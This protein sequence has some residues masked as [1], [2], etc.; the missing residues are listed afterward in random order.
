M[1][2]PLPWQTADILAATGGI[3]ISGETRR[4]FA[5]VSID[6]RSITP[7]EV[8]VAIKG[9]THDGHRFIPEAI[10][11]GAGG[12]LIEKGAGG[13]LP[14]ALIKQQRLIC[15]GVDD[16]TRALG[17]LAAFNRR[18]SRVSVVAVT[19]SNGKTTTR[20]MTAACVAG[21]FQVL[22]PAGNFNNQ[23]G[24]PLTL[25][26]LEKA[27]EWA[28]L[29]LGMNR[30][31]EIGRLAEICMPQIGVITN[32]GSAHIEG[33]GSIEGIMEAKGELLEKIDTG[34]SAV[35]NADDPRVLRLAGRAARNVLLFGSSKDAAVRCESVRREGLGTAFTLVLPSERISVC[36]KIPGSFM[37]SNALAAASVGHLIGLSGREIAS[38]LDAFEPASGRMSVFQTENGINIIDDTYNANPDSMA[39]A[40]RTLSSSL[41][42]AR[43]ILVMGDM[44]ELGR[45]AESMHRSIGALSAGSGIKRL[46]ATGEFAEAVAAGA[47]DAN[48]DFRQIVTGTKEEILNDLSGRLRPG[49]WVLVKGSRAMGMETIVA[50]LRTGAGAGKSGA[51]PASTSKNKG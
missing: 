2:H 37:V 6:S 19:G 45:H 8:F 34:G 48:M 25:L 43:G 38:G 17:D 49:D 35:L 5:G 13:G 16:T 24:L 28:V 15:V 26:K 23:I 32:I 1:T 18:R 29:E 33:L 39:A 7:G 12:L 31:G 46:Y 14:Q 9:D 47:V 10:R 40:I 22:E 50:R 51:D 30:P 20:K 4:S 44:L 3:L 42:G 27:H 21:R 41:S 36:L 11:Q